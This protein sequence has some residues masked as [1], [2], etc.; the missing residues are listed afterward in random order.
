[1]DAAGGIAR[2]SEIEPVEDG[3]VRDCPIQSEDP[4]TAELVDQFTTT[5][6][7]EHALEDMGRIVNSSDNAFKHKHGGV[8]WKDLTVSH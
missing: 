4:G 7:Y 3:D 2:V 1:M 8:I 6:E 5:T